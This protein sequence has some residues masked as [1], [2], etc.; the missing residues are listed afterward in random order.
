MKEV[1]FYHEKLHVYQ[2]ALQFISWAEDLIQEVLRKAAVKDQIDRASTSIVLNIAEGNGK[3]P[4]P[5]RRRFLLIA[6]G[7]AVECA[8]CLDVFVAKR[9]V[10][11]ERIWPGKELLSEI[12]RMLSGLIDSIEM[13]VREEEAEYRIANEDIEG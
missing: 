10:D 2:K 3:L 7:S 5:E 13:M 9:L 11:E 1:L 6:R 4:G 8:A 12:V